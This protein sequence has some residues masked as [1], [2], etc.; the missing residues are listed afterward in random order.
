MFA[1]GR[2]MNCF[3]FLQT[4]ISDQKQ[5]DLQPKKKQRWKKFSIHMMKKL[6]TGVFLQHD[7]EIYVVALPLFLPDFSL[8]HPKQV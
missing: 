2:L 7:S 5:L 6:G 3:H 4:Y 8:K 1:L